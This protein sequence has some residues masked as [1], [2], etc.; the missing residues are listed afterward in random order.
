MAKCKKFDSGGNVDNV[1]LGKYEDIYAR[2]TPIKKPLPSE[3]K[4]E[5]KPAFDKYV[6][7]PFRKS[8]DAVSVYLESKAFSVGFRIEHPQSLIDRCRFGVCCCINI[9][10]MTRP[11]IEIFKRCAV[12]SQ[13][14]RY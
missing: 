11:K 7:E 14:N 13:S 1:G 2:K 12:Q 6:K 8:N 3:I 9:Q 4:K 5:D 10:C